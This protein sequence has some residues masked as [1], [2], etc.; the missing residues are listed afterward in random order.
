MNSNLENILKEL[1]Q[2]LQK[3]C[4]LL[5]KDLAFREREL[6][7]RRIE[8]ESEPALEEVLPPAESDEDKRPVGWLKKQLEAENVKHEIYETSEGFR[9]RV[10]GNGQTVRK[11]KNWVKWT[12]TRMLEKLS[13]EK[14]KEFS[15]KFLKEGDSEVKA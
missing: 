11:V 6:Q 3:L 8:R 12:R 13:P 14:V 7:W 9:V 2:T 4:D 5:E 1:N 10:W 15:S